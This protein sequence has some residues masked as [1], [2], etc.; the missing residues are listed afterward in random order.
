MRAMKMLTM[1]AIPCEEY[2][3]RAVQRKLLTM[4]LFAIFNG[5]VSYLSYF[6]SLIKLLR[7]CSYLAPDKVAS[8]T[9]FMNPKL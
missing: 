8:F 2:D 9:D 5:I 6:F 4:I 7:Q 3:S 1:K